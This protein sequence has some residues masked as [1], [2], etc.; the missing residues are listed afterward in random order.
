MTFKVFIRQGANG[1]CIASV[2]SLPGCHSQ[3][4]TF[5]EA[6][7]NIKEAIVG[8]IKVCK[9]YGDSFMTDD[10]NLYEATIKF[11]QKEKPLTRV[12]A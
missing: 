4:K 8:Y 7:K 10:E 1:W 5:E 3:G 2:P 12:L 11:P 9:K 6:L